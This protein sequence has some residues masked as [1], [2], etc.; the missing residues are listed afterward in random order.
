MGEGKQTCMKAPTLDK[1]LIQNVNYDF[2]GKGVF[3]IVH[4]LFTGILAYVNGGQIVKG[5]LKM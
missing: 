2:G 4:I 5:L 1:R 3:I